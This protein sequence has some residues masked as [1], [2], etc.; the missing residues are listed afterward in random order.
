M[1]ILCGY[2]RIVWRKQSNNTMNFS[3][4]DQKNVGGLLFGVSGYEDRQLASMTILS[5]SVSSD[6]KV[7]DRK[8]AL[9]AGICHPAAV[10]PLFSI[11]SPPCKSSG[12]TTITRKSLPSSSLFSNMLDCRFLYIYPLPNMDFSP[13]SIRTKD[14]TL[15]YD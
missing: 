6:T 12:L 11:D 5:S 1:P 9:L 2:G 15:F 8:K 14:F 7:P 10:S 3:A 13:I 4:V